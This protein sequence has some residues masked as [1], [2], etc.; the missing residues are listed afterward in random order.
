MLIFPGVSANRFEGQSLEKPVIL[1]TIRFVFSMTFVVM[2]ATDTST[3]FAADW[4]QINGSNRNGIATGETLLSQWPDDGL[5]EQWSH[6]VGQGF[7]GP[8]VAGETLV[9]FHRPGKRYLVEALNAKT[10]KLIWNKELAAQYRGGGPDGDLGPKSTPL[11]HGKHIYLLGT[12]GN[13][14]CLTLAHGTVVWQKNVLR[15]YDSPTGY[16]GAG[17]SPIVINEKLLVNVGGKNAAVVAFDLESG[18]E[19]WKS[20]DDR[21]SYSSPIETNNGDE[22][23]AVFV[24]RMHLIGLEPETGQVL[25]Q[26]P[27]GKRGPTVNAAMPVRLSQHLFINAAYGVGA[28]WIAVNGKRAEKVWDNDE[29]FSSQYSTPVVAGGMLFG[30][31]GREDYGNGSYRCV[32]PSSGKVMWKRDRF[33]V[34][35][36][37]LVGSQ[38]IVLDSDGGF[39]VIA[40][41]ASKFDRVYK[42]R[43]FDMKSRALPALS[44]GLFYARSNA[45]HK[46]GE[47]VCVRVGPSPR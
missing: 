14:F 34:G 8:V 21:A 41:D 47:L 22:P 38:I 24:T 11:V 33:P 30:T 12:G 17:S 35:H 4:P 19:Q 42:T 7:S 10:G 36:S 37:I 46:R 27:F 39:H 18:T 28:Q 25:F 44:D 40:A 43:L 45:D 32:D 15:E 23:V 13:L 20:F 3:T 31:S 1:H 29:S 16:F 2:L 9:I 26:L 6:P 5:E